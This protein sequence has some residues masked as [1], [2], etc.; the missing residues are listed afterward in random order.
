MSGWKFEGTQ[1]KMQN[2]ICLNDTKKYSFLQRTID[3]WNGLK[4]RGGNGKEC[5]TIEG[6]IGQI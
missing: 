4:N 6:K 5:I 2:G 3:T 1:E